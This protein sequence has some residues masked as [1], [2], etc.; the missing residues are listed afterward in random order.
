MVTV[1]VLPA[2]ICAKALNEISSLPLGTVRDL[3]PNGGMVAFAEE[4]DTL[5]LVIESG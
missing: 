1:V 3:K 4:T 5:R 2:S